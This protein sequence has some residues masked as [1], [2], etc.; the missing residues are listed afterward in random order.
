MRQKKTRFTFGL[1]TTLSLLA[2]LLSGCKSTELRAME[3]SVSI[4]QLTKG[5]EVL[6]SLREKDWGF[7]GPIYP[8]VIIVYEPINNHT[9]KEVYDEIVAILKKNNWE[10]SEPNM[11]HDYFE[12]FLHQG[13]YKISAGVSIDSHK[14][15]IIF[16][17]R[18]Y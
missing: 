1:V 5:R 15:Q 3:N 10:G 11:G 9:N 8:Q 18:I 12:A 16:I 6:R 7:T 17:T 4:I 13:D 14:N 2:L